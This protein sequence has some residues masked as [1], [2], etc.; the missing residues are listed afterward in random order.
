MSSLDFEMRRP[1]KKERELR[2]EIVQK[3]QVI[4]VHQIQEE[5]LIN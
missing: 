3:T 2:E 5:H 4:A 1:Y